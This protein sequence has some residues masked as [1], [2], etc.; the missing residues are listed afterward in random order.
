L[1]RNPDVRLDIEEIPESFF[2]FKGKALMATARAKRIPYGLGLVRSYL[3][4]N[5]RHR[6][7]T[8][9]LILRESDRKMM[10][11][12]IQAKIIKREKVTA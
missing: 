4:C 7:E 11:N 5:G 9:G 6:L 3:P 2:L 8:V 10:E 1:S 12:A